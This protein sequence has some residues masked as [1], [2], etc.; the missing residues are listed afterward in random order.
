MNDFCDVDGWRWSERAACRGTDPESWFA[1]VRPGHQD[2]NITRL[3]R[4]CAE[5]PVRVECLNYAL[6]NN[7]WGIWGGTT[8][9]ERRSR[10]GK[11]KRR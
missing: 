8:D 1:D 11:F 6:D 7:E 5:C 10:T 9:D 4:I 3:R 2:E